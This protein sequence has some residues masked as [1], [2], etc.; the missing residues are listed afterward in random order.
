MRHG[1]YVFDRAVTLQIAYGIFF[2]F[3]VKK[4]YG[5]ICPHTV[6]HELLIY[7]NLLIYSYGYK[8]TLIN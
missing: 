4:K 3:K 6:L 1:C 7:I 2:I 8:A 5:N